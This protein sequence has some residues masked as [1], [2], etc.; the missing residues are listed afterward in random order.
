M[1]RINMKSS[2]LLTAIVSSFVLGSCQTTQYLESYAPEEG[3]LNVMKITDESANTVL[4]P[5]TAVLSSGDSFASSSKGGSKAAKFYWSTMRLLDISPD[6]TELAYLS[7]N[8]KQDNIMIRRST[9]QGAATQRTF[10]HLNSFSWGHDNQLYFS[11]ISDNNY[12]QICTTDAHVGSLLRQL[13]NNNYDRDPVVTSDGSLMFFTRLDKSGPSIWSLDLKNGALTSCARG[14]NPCVIGEEKDAF[15]CVRN[16]SN[17]QSEIWKVNYV[18]GQETL[19]LTDKNR[20]YTNPRVSPDGLWIVCEGNSKSSI[21]K[22]N[23]LD[24]FAALIDGTSVVQL[25]YHPAND[26]SPVFSKDGKSIYFISDRANKN[27]EYNIWRMRF[28]L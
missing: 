19:I 17:G 18:L 27:E 15:I 11:D 24:I 10:R 25:T 22:K 21:T 1:K 12:S 13:T 4:G 23:N 28:D 20:S 7:R 2:S 5:T 3:G 14:Y 6:G 26:C 16:N 8:N 9:A